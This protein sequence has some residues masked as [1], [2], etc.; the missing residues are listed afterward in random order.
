MEKNRC[1]YRFFHQ[2]SHSCIP[3]RKQVSIVNKDCENGKAGELRNMKPW[4]QVL[5]MLPLGE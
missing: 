5:V 2:H 4:V 3:L 1:K